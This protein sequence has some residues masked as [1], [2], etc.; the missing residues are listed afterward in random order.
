MAH[1]ALTKNDS[2]T[3]GFV[4]ACLF[5]GAIDRQELR[6]WADY[7]LTTTDSC[8]P[9]VADLSTFDQP[10]SHIYRLIG[11]VPSSGLTDSERIGLVGIAVVRGRGQFEPVP[12]KE[13]ALTALAAHRDLVPRFREI[14]PFISLEYDQVA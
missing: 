5:K 3:I 9:Y 14:F 6:A 13:E 11:F 7:V 2:A 1:L 8:P 12:T 4:L 10:L